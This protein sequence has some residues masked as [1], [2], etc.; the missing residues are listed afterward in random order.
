MKAWILTAFYLWKDIW[1]R[2]LETPGALL[3]RLLVAFLLAGLMLLGQAAFILAGRSLESRVTRM[4]AQT[5]VINEAVSGGPDR[6]PTL[7][8]MLQPVPDA[9]LLSL[10]QASVQA[11]DEY[12]TSLR[13]MVYGPESAP[14]L[15]ALLGAA[16]DVAVHTFNPV[17]P[18]GLPLRVTLDGRDYPAVNLAAPASLQRIA[19]GQALVLVPAA[20]GDAWLSTGW[21]ETA[22]LFDRSGDLPLLAT[23]VRTLLQLEDRRHAQLQSPEALLHELQELRQLQHR[24]QAAGG[25]IGGVVIALLFGSIAILEYRQNRYVAA[26]LRSCGAPASLLTARYAVDALLIAL[27]AILAARFTLAAVHGALFAPLGLETTLLDRNLV[28]PY[29]WPL[30]WQQTRWLALGALVSLL[31]VSLSLREPVGRVLQ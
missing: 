25:V 16:P 21:F 30:V 19:S 5:L 12:G 18:A 23:A 13:V 4:G 7:G 15:A 9:G 2:W 26:L 27:A 31:P 28:D 1:S 8:S 20:I 29:A 10:R 11:Q 22:F 14:A 24:T 17:L 3:A 6:Q